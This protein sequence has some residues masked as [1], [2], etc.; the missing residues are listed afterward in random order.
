[1]DAF[2]SALSL[3]IY[4]F[5]VVVV[6][7]LLTSR[8][9]IKSGIAP[10]IVMCTTVMYAIL[11]GTLDLLFPAMVGYYV[12]VVFALGY[13][14]YRERGRAKEFMREFF[15]PS[16]LF[17]IVV[18]VLMTLLFA[19]K[20]P[21]FREWDEFSFWGTSAKLIKINDRLYTL[22]ESSLLGRASPGAL[23]MLSYVVQ[24]LTK[25][26]IEWGAYLAYDFLYIAS[27]A[28]LMARINFKRWPLAVFTGALGFML[29]YMFDVYTRMIYLVKTYISVYAD[30][31]LGVLFGAAV[32]VYY[33]VESDDSRL[34]VPCS[35]MLA[36]LPTIKE[37]GFA[38][39][40]VCAFI[41]TVDIFFVRKQF[42]FLKLKGL[43]AKFAS[44]AMLFLAPI[45]TFL[46]WA[47]HLKTA[48]NLNRFELGG[49][50]D[51]GM[52]EMLFAGLKELVSPEKSEKF[53]AISQK[54]IDAFFTSKVS[55]IGAGYVVVGL[56]FAILIVAYFTIGSKEGRRRIVLFSATSTIGFIAYYI[57]HIFT[58]VYIFRDVEAYGLASYNRYIYIFYAGWL[59]AAIVLLVL[60]AFE[61]K[62]QIIASITLTG[63]TV[64]IVA[65]FSYCV[66]LNL[67]FIDFN[68][69]EF[70]SR[71]QVVTAVAAE[72][73]LIADDDKAYF[74]SQGDN[75]MRWFVFTFEFLPADLVKVY[76]GGTLVSKF[77]GQLYETECT[78]EQFVAH[79]RERGCTNIYVDRVDQYFIE[80]FGALFEDDLAYYNSG[81]HYYEI[82]DDGSTFLLRP[83][84]AGA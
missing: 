1:M 44:S 51:M 38:L 13:T 64:V 20:Q 66:R 16:I 82:I 46:L 78:A 83:A 31:P 34:I 30:L 22:F 28:A 58:Y 55:M 70:S 75:G 42:S 7:A 5:S 49:A 6:S 14:I 52:F 29:P 79:L 56:I 77:T 68:A 60:S 57:F 40:L 48:L 71:T 19:T 21:I 4:I 24:F 84:K 45:A 9:K 69:S 50:A 67:T 37:V 17:F 3:L 59:M 23:P 47:K 27:Y 8:A 54:M 10:V 26:F 80:E 53:V 18:C 81:G 32:A 2:F 76:G 73:E 62:R 43:A 36:M 63:L 39:A 41:M 33:S 11:F 72:R 65:V 25:G 12:F 74:I 61:G 35:I 15:T